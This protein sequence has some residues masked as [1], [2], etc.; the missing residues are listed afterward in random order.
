MSN[1]AE[2]P[3][4]NEVRRIFLLP[5]PKCGIQIEAT[6]D[7][8]GTVASC[9]CGQ[10]YRLAL[11]IQKLPIEDDS[12][13]LR[14]QRGCIAFWKCCTDTWQQSI[15]PRTVAFCQCVRDKWF[16]WAVDKT[17]IAYGHFAKWFK[18][19]F[20]STNSTDAI[21]SASAAGR[22]VA[23]ALISAPSE[24]EGAN[25]D[26]PDEVDDEPTSVK[27]FFSSTLPHSV[28]GQPLSESTSDSQ[29]LYRLANQMIV[30]GLYE[31][32]YAHASQAVVLDPSNAGAWAAKGIAAAY[33]S[34]P[35]EFRLKETRMCLTESLKSA[36]LKEFVPSLQQ[37]LLRAS[38]NYRKL[39]RQACQ[40]ADDDAQREPLAGNV[41]V[42]LQ[43]TLRNKRVA[44]VQTQKHRDGYFSSIDAIRYAAGLNPTFHALELGLRE[45]DNV[46]SK[47]SFPGFVNFLS[48]D[49]KRDQIVRMR[50]G[51]ISQI[52]EIRPSFTPPEIPRASGCFI[53][54]AAAGDPFHQSVCTLRRFRDQILLPNSIG[55]RFV[56]TYYRISPPLA[57]AI[58]QTAWQRRLVF[59][60][61]VRPLSMAAEYIMLKKQSAPWDHER[62]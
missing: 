49:G 11:V 36:E 22:P 61:V 13:W 17:Q 57:A 26:V 42:G 7:R 5:C 37:H 28:S 18:S 29:K 2:N 4:P 54:T 16:P 41:D 52:R 6:A 10:Q 53:A 19:L 44:R 39:L 3:A 31:D 48:E 9:E 40:D 62:S 14:G 55:R 1:S 23:A 38:S 25:G 32:A 21:R 58:R 45:I 59:A 27:D 12:V 30:A 35:P 43:L 33:A 46:L 60:T 34:K 15:W 8:I 51:F 47:D 20:G 56:R 50:E 24:T